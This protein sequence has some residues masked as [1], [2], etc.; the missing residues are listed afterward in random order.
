MRFA[1]L[2]LLVMTSAA[3]SAALAQ[4]GAGSGPP[5][6]ASILLTAHASGAV[7]MTKLFQPKSELQTMAK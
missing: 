4:E 1:L 5:K 6:K 7:A 3:T 2:T